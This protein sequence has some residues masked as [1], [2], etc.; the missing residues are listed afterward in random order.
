MALG[1]GGL[2]LGLCRGMEAGSALLIGSPDMRRL[3][4][5]ILGRLGWW[6]GHDPVDVEVG[7]G[8]GCGGCGFLH[9]TFA[10]AAM[11]GNLD[12][13]MVEPVEGLVGVWYWLGWQQRPALGVG[14]C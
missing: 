14:E 9:S 6:W 1:P 10:R 4:A 3:G 11:V 7:C 12:G 5:A 8:Q 13:W 2:G